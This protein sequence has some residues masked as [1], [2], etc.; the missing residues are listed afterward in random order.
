MDDAVVR[1]FVFVWTQIK[2]TTP[3]H[4]PLPTPQRA[5]KRIAARVLHKRLPAEH[6]QSAGKKKMAAVDSST[7]QRLDS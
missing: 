1:D 3:H 6:V 2:S 7:L 4:L 5:Q